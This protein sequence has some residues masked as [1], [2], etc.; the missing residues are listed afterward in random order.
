MICADIC[1]YLFG[2]VLGGVS[3]SFEVKAS[4]GRGGSANEVVGR[5]GR[6]GARLRIDGHFRARAG[7][8]VAVVGAA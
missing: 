1:N 5:S 3:S 6:S 7:R 4:E 2:G 8:A